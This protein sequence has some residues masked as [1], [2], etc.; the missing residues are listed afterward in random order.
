[1]PRPRKP[2]ELLELSGAFERVC[3][4]HLADHPLNGNTFGV[5][6]TVTPLVDPW[7]GERRLP[8]RMRAVPKPGG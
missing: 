6:G 8:D 7:L 3:G 1:M 5:V 2:T 4:L